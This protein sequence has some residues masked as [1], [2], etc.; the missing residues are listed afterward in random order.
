M[1]KRHVAAS[2]PSVL[3]LEEDDVHVSVI[4]QGKRGLGQPCQLTISINGGD[5]V[6]F[7]EDAGTAAPKAAI[8]SVATPEGV[9]PALRSA[10]R[11]K[12]WQH[13]DAPIISFS[14]LAEIKDE[15]PALG[16]LV[17]NRPISDLI[18]TIR[19]A[20]DLDPLPN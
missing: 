1:L 2:A 3:L 4:R 10:L 11:T 18:D 15:P 20:L 17:R 8:I 9:A 19:D 7:L 6:S 16:Y 12:P 5:P 14:E 13:H